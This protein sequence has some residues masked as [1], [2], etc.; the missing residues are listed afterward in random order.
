MNSLSIA[1]AQILFLP[2]LDSPVRKA[3]ALITE[4]LHRLF[5]G[6]RTSCLHRIEGK[7][8]GTKGVGTNR[9][10]AQAGK[11]SADNILGI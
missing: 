11:A 10:L 3:M 8:Q 6:I 7:R 5:R 4:L 2:R 1:H 9:D